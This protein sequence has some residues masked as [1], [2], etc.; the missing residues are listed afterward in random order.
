MVKFF[1]MGSFESGPERHA[2]ATAAPTV[3][4]DG[5]RVLVGGAVGQGPGTGRRSAWAAAAARGE[6]VGGE[7]A[8]VAPPTR[9]A[10]SRQEVRA[11]LAA[12][13]A[14]NELI[15]GER[16]FVAETHPRRDSASVLSAKINDNAR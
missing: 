16:V 14:N 13:R 9:R 5:L 3:G 1:M 8:F 11:E 15:Q 2:R 7:L 12:A 4:S 6:L 10:L